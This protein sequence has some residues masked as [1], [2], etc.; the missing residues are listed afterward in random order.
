M[1]VVITDY[2]KMEFEEEKRVFESVGAKLEIAQCRTEDEVIEASLGATGLINS[3]IP[4]TRKIIESLPELK[5]IAKYSI[6]VDNIDV[7]AATENNVFVANVPDYCQEEVSNH[8]LALIMTLTR[9]IVSLNQSVKQGKWSF[10]EGVPLHR[11]STQTVGLISYGSIA[12]NLSKKLTA[13]GF[14]VIAYDPY[15][16]SANQ[17]TNVELVSLEELM[18]RSDVISI[19]SPLIKETYHLVNKEVLELAKPGAI[20]INT[21][22][23]SVINEADLINALK[24]GEISGAGL[25]VLE[26][27][28]MDVSNPLLSMENVIL[29]PHIAFYTEESIQELKRKTA[30]NIVDVLQGGKP[31]YLVNNLI[32]I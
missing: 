22:R 28:P 17:E 12:R 21:G 29:T 6:G 9:K 26:Q 16:Q 25:D 3:E 2:N 18:G 30:L 13:I 5:V 10:H 1:K 19:H 20:I 27:E 7:E 14:K 32:K 23:G 15:Y 11:F 4:I 31:R 24:T 8:A